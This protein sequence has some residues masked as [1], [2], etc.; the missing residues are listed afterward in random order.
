MNQSYLLFH[1]QLT[2][3]DSLTTW[4]EAQSR[5]NRFGIISTF[6]RHRGGM[7]SLHT[8]SILSPYDAHTNGDE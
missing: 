1:Y 7:S 6:V 2:G 8:N 3:V 4:S 5:P